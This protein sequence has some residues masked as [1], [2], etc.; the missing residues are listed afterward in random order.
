MASARQAG[1]RFAPPLFAATSAQ[2]GWSHSA[3]W[4]HGMNSV[5]GG[6]PQPP[7]HAGSGGGAA[8]P[9]GGPFFHAL[10]PGGGGGRGG[11]ATTTRSSTPSRHIGHR[12]CAPS[13]AWH[14]AD[15]HTG[16]WRHGSSATQMQ[17]CRQMTHSSRSASAAV[18]A[19]GGG[20]VAGC[21]GAAAGCGGG[22][23]DDAA[24][25][26]AGA[27]GFG[28]D[29]GSSEGAGEVLGGEAAGA[30]AG[31]ESDSRSHGMSESIV[32]GEDARGSSCSSAPNVPNRTA[33]AA[34]SPP[35]GSAALNVPNCMGT[36]LTLSGS[37]SGVATAPPKRIIGGSAS[38]TGCSA[39]ASAYDS[40][41][42]PGACSVATA[43]GSNDSL[44]SAASSRVLARIVSASKAL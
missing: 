17:S 28:G 30:A 25:G 7:T 8:K 32:L 13:M 11:G 22:D 9:G 24:V 27:G 33:A 38:A 35:A 10:T 3:R 26:G 18:R 44:R 4:R 40:G 16:K 12:G 42:L 6:D 23:C 36:S 39:T 43:V 1:Q 19:A 31:P 41:S 15:A 37:A 2:R 34:S 14:S 29:A 20:G 5:L 21:D